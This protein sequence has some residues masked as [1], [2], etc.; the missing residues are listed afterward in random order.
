[1]LREARGRVLE[2]MEHGECDVNAVA[3]R[4]ELPRQPGRA[5]LFD[6]VLALD[7][8]PLRLRFDGREAL[9]LPID[10]GTSKCDL[11]FLLEERG[12]AIEGR[13]E[14][15]SDLFEEGS[16][17]RLRDRLLAL[18]GAALRQPDLPLGEHWRRL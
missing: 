4:L 18:L 9:P 13:I 1:L 12:S 16:A 8:A 17:L 6:V 7:A 3:R 10:P 11:A 5:P 2:A 14:Y 15:D